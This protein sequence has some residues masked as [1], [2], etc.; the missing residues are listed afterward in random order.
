LYQLNETLTNHRAAQLVKLCT[1]D[2]TTTASQFVVTW[3][4]IDSYNKVYKYQE[5]EANKYGFVKVGKVLAKHYANQELALADVE[6]IKAAYK[7]VNN[8]RTGKS[9]QGQGCVISDYQF[10]K[11]SIEEPWLVWTSKG[12]EKF[13]DIINK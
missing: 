9:T 5:K 7:A 6:N 1:E 12:V 10:G 8:R 11:M 3:V 13:N 2:M 4:I